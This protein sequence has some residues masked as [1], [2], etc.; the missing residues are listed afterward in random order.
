M[1]LKAQELRDFVPE[2]YRVTDGLSLLNAG[3]TTLVCLAIGYPFAYFMARSSTA[4]QPLLVMDVMLPFWA[5]FLLRVY[6]WKGLLDADTG[7]V[8]GVLK[9]AHVDLLLLALGWISALGQL[10][11]SPFSLVLG[12]V[13]TYLP[14]MVR[15]LY[16]KLAKM[17]LRLPEAA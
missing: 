1:R 8:G 9:W 10:M 4:A 12:M 16:G 13:D 6:A 2:L 3:V 14:F 17:D 7:W 5:S 11:Y 15:P